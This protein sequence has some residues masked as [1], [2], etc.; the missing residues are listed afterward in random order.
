[1]LVRTCAQ[2]PSLLGA[3]RPAGRGVVFSWLLSQGVKAPSCP[4]THLLCFLG[5]MSVYQPGGMFWLWLFF[6][7]PFCLLTFSLKEI[8]L[9]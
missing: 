1:M 3:W 4:A 8:G 6:F 5:W 9:S 7:C 2:G